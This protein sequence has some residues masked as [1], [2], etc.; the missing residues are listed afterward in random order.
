MTLMTG[1]RIRYAVLVAMVAM[2]PLITIQMLGVAYQRK[3][4][5]ASV[6]E[7]VLPVEEDDDDILDL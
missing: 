7:Q 3:L 6:T 4:S 2:T 1:K 5:K